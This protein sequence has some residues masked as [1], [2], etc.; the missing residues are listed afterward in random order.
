MVM[1]LKGRS[2]IIT[3]ASQGL[4]KAIAAS[5]VRAGASVLLV[6]R[7]EGKLQAA[8]QELASYATQPGQV[9]RAACGDVSDPVSCAAI[10]QQ[11]Q[12][13]LPDITI[14]VNNAGVYGPMGLIEDVAW[15]AWV[16][17]IQINLFGTV[18]MCRQVIPLMRAQG[19]G[20]IVNLS[21]GG[22]TAPLP[23]IS[24]YAAAKAAIV[25]LTETFAVELGDAHIDVNA[26]APGALNTRLLDEVLAAGPEKVGQDF[27][28]RAVKQHDEGGVP[29][30]Q[31]AALAVFLA[32]A[33]SDGISGRLLSAVWD[34]WA[35]LPQ[36][37]DQLAQSDIYTLRRIVPED[38]GSKW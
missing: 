9:V 2:A 36:R 3:G 7:N 11:A 18:L 33:A 15:E 19:Y 28:A 30:E 22:A 23:R 12:A 16:E 10:V 26:I 29:L 34:N 25:R 14:L 13:L 20:K 8:Q 37:S 31:G 38:R 1:E 21:G 27:Y 24:A 32:S 6:A 35:S 5:F 17:A 4:G